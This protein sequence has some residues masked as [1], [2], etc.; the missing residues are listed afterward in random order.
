L[1]GIRPRADNILE[2]HPLL[3]ENKWDWFCLDNLLY[4]GKTVTVIWD[5]NGTHFNKGTGLAVWV[6]GKKI[7]ASLKLEKLIATF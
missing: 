5:K 7:A 1:V 4:H 6:N 2:L 3:P